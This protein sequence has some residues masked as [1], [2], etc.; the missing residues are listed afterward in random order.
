MGTASEEVKMQ[1]KISGEHVYERLVEF[2]LWEEYGKHLD[3]DVADIKNIGMAEAGQISAGKFLE[4]FVDY[5]WIHLDIAGTA[6]LTGADSYRGKHATG[7]P[8]RL[9][10]DFLSS[11]VK[12]QNG[13]IFG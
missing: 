12:S 1:L 7:S 10:Y 2:P 5:P 6:F 8:V 4:H 11:Q 3:S 9:I 13:S